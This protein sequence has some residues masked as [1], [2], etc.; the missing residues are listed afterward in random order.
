MTK[1][2][3][4][5]PFFFYSVHLAVE[6]TFSDM[7]LTKTQLRSTLEEDILYQTLKLCTEG[8]PTLSDEDIDLVFK[9]ENSRNQDNN[10]YLL[11]C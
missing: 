3:Q 10:L 7:K 2:G 1:I 11:E 6:R 5:D 9:I 8:P 4:N